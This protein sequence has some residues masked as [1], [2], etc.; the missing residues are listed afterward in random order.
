MKL[1]PGTG[2]APITK[3][4]DVYPYC[5][6]CDRPFSKQGPTHREFNRKAWQAVPRHFVGDAR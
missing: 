2:K 4:A 3:H 1:C 5:P 6:E